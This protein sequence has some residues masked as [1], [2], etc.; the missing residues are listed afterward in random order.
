MKAVIIA[1]SVGRGI[2]D[3]YSDVEVGVFWTKPPSEGERRAL[4]ERVGVV[5]NDL[6]LYRFDPEDPGSEE[7][8]EDMSH[9]RERCKLSGVYRP[10]KTKRKLVG[11]AHP[12]RR[13]G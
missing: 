12:T 13:R 5:P 2:A 4:A 1:G 8:D 6:E 11:N 10:S 3:R 9:Q 7:A